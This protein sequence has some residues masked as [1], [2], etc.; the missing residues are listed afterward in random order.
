[1]KKE[2]LGAIMERYGSL[3]ALK[4]A[5]SED[6]DVVLI[7]LEDDLDFEYS[8]LEILEYIHKIIG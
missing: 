2:I 1:M 5:M 6:E 8:E 7:N 3:T 4:G